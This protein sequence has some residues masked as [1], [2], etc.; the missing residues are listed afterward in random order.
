[1]HTDRNE[2]CIYTHVDKQIKMTVYMKF[3]LK[4]TSHSYF[5]DW[6]T[7]Y[8]MIGLFKRIIKTPAFNLQW[9]A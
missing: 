4:V 2:I 1:M 5:Y 3:V 9:I 6:Y 8:V 7:Y